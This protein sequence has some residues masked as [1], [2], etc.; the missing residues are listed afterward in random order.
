MKEAE[1]VSGTI[2]TDMIMGILVY[3]KLDD[4]DRVCS[5]KHLFS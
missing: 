2:F 5:M 3:Q 4:E 1:S